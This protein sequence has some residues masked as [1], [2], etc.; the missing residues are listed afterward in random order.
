MACKAVKKAVAKAKAEAYRALYEHLDTKE[1]EKEA[2]RLAKQRDKASKDVQQVRNIRDEDG[3]VLSSEE[4]I[5][6]RW[7]GYFEKLMNEC[8]CSFSR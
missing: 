3:N 2:Y 8:T 5:L 4:D 6:D 1:G 7:K